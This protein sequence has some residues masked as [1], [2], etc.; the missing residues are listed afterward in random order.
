MVHGVGGHD[1]LSNL[2]RTYQSFRANLKSVE[3]PIPGEDQIPSWR[4]T[5]FDESASPPFL[6]LEPDVEPKPGSVGAVCL[7]EVNYSGF[8]G[9]IRRNHP[10]D[11]TDLFLGLD[12]SVC[13]A[14]QRPVVNAAPVFAGDTT[15]LGRTLQRLCSVLTAGTVPIIG[16]PSIIFR[17]YIGTFV[18]V[19]T[20]FFEDI[21]T[22]ALDKNGEQL[23][24]AHLD[25][26]MAV[27]AAT[28]AT[29]DRLVVAAHSLGS[30]VVHNYVVRQ[31]RN[32]TGPLPDTL[33]TFGS[34][35][36]LLTWL[37]LFLDFRNMNIKERLSAGDHYFSWNPVGGGGQRRAISWINVVNCVDPIATAFPT[38][39]C[40]LSATAATAAAGLKD[41]H[42]KQRFFGVAGITSVGAAHT[43]YLNDKKGFLDILLRA[44]GLRDGEPE[45]VP[46]AR[47]SS[48]HWAESQKVLGRVQT[49]LYVVA[50]AAIAAYCYLVSR[51]LGDPRA[52]WN[53][54]IFAWPAVTIGTLATFQRLL[55]GGPT[56]RIPPP[57][58]EELPWRDLSAF[59]YKLRQ[60]V[61]IIL[62]VSR[63]VDRQ[64]PSRGYFVRLL[65][66]AISFIPTLGAMLIPIA[67]TAWLTGRWSGASALLE[68][69]WSLEGLLLLA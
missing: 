3:A 56:K 28:M 2:L 59:P 17:D 55:L 66:S 52:M 40:D 18:A 60:R 34:P 9:V 51:G 24:S 29:G 6:R 47:T 57:A 44:A 7:Y 42:V 30:V 35:I 65:I 58:I 41:G 67:G 14:R 13:L 61:R 53:V 21:A 45:D 19:F 37:W 16:L 15:A 49:G 50:V 1:H 68:R 33:I 39:A 8:A 43:E 25:R 62:G 23:I 26:T 20:R 12:L 38:G 54:A 48:E 27:I 64:A 31:T 32:A 22:F 4:L 11:L 46:G 10:I 36:G 63:E 69:A 5:R